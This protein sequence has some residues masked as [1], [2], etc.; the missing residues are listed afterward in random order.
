MPAISLD[1]AQA[2]LR[3]LVHGLL[4]GDHVVITE[5]SLPIAHLVAATE[6][7]RQRTLGTMQGTVTY[8]AP[9]FDAPL[10]VCI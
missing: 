8:M 7:S 9:D 6:S 2:N 5:N 3:E 1:E 4:P 10:E